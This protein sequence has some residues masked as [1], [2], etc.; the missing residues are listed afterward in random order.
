M[1]YN[2]E[3]V[4]DPKDYRNTSFARRPPSRPPHPRERRGEGSQGAAGKLKGC[5]LARLAAAHG[6]GGFSVAYKW[7]WI[8]VTFSTGGSKVRAE[9]QRVAAAIFW[10]CAGPSAM[11]PG[12]ETPPP[13]SSSLA[14]CPSR[15]LLPGPRAGDR[16]RAGRE[17]PGRPWRSSALKNRA[18]IPG[19]LPLLP[20]RALG[21]G[22]SGLLAR[23]LR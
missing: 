6:K 9:P 20:G 13:S 2:L 11:R 12:T 7:P 10:D 4:S 19:P 1:R 14:E 18:G 15:E 3:K 21:P 22:S 5:L 8:E 17:A 23:L 16:A